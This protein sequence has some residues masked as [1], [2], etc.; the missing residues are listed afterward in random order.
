VGDCRIQ[1][2]GANRQVT[3]SRYGL[4]AGG[5]RLVVDYGMFQERAYLSRNWDPC[6]V[7]ASRIDA[8]LLTH[9]HLDHCGLLPKLVR[10]GFRG[11]ILT[12]EP[13]IDLTEVILRDSARIQEED[14]RYKRKR[15]RRENRESPHPYVPLYTE[16]DVAQTLSLFRGLQYREPVHLNDRVTV[17]FHDAGHILGS[18]MIEVVVEDGA[19]PHRIVFSGDVGQKDKPFVENPSTFERADNVVLESTYGD[20]D[21][22]VG[23]DAEEALAKVVLETVDRGGNAVIPTFALERAQELMYHIGR[24]HRAGRIPKLP[25]FLDSP[26]AVDVT[27]IFKRHRDWFDEEARRMIESEEPPLHFPGLRLTRSVADSKAINDVR[28]PCIIMASS[29]MCTGGRIKHHLIRNLPRRESTV[30]FVGYQAEGTLGRRILEGDDPVRIHGRQWPVRARIER[31][32]GFSAHAG[33]SA[34]VHWTD[35]FRECPN[36]IF[37][38]HGDLDAAES[39]ARALREAHPDCEV[40]IPEYGETAELR[41]RARGP[42]VTDGDRRTR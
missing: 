25:V 33:R 34:L 13:T 36:R 6:P 28:G 15:H 26:M 29:G 4:E 37:L 2:L 42:S 8:V 35:H 16:E 38:T 18:S 32:T 19:D 23:A 31:I 21:H 1:F 14:V 10:E 9:A 22:P 40:T 20:R 24:L 7:P 17:T 39:L 12:T 27:N 5:L 41:S 11:T 30:V 3:G